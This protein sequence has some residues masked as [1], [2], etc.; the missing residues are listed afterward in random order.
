MNKFLYSV[1][2]SAVLFSGCSFK[3]TLPQ[4]NTEFIADYGEIR[5]DKAWWAEFGDSYLNSLVESALQNN[6]DLNLAL[7]N[8]EIARTSLG[9]SRLEF[10]PNSQIQGGAGRQNNFGNLPDRNSHEAYSLGASMSYEIDFWGKI[11]NSVRAANA[12]FNATKY[13]YET[14]KNTIVSTVANLYF[15][16]ISLKEQEQI[17]KS[18]LDSYTSTANFRKKQLNA[19]AISDIVYYQALA[20]QE[21]A[22]ANL[23]GVQN[24][25][26]QISTSLNIL[27]G[28]S[29][30]EILHGV[31]NS[32]NSLP[33]APAIP[34]GISSDIL[35]HR[36]DVASALERLKATNFLVGVAK[37]QYFPSISLT[38]SLGYASGEFDTLLNNPAWSIAG[39]LVG[40]LIDFGRTK[41]RVDLANLD[42]NASFIAYDK[43]LKTAF[44]EVKDALIGVENAKIKQ[45]S[46]KKLVSAQQ[47]V[48]NM[49]SK[50]YDEGYSDH[51]EFLDAQ[52][53]LLNSKLSL[54]NANLET[55]TSTV[56][57]YKALG[58]GFKVDDNDTINLTNSKE[59]IA[60]SSSAFPTPSF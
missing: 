29:Y 8:I 51:L 4:K 37:A 18:S 48:F 5:I 7:N 10:L 12:K 47:R 36:P 56:N 22:R 59:E 6:S 27:T 14:A 30:N 16:L 45:E 28:K 25:L 55:L 34:S 32:A 39:S 38:G 41:K 24:N 11:R 44:G 58:G 60:P 26:S 46:M 1:I 23:I 50:R 33:N 17:L 54:A 13:D 15:T 19:G 31:V 42:Q 2:A 3:P 49:A 35:L 21:N 9:L 40:P 52:R 43:T 53:G 20:T 57:A